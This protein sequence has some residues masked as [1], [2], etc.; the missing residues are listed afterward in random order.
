MFETKNRSLLNTQFIIQLGHLGSG[1]RCGKGSLG[2]YKTP[3]MLSCTFSLGG[4]PGGSGG[5]PGRAW[6][7]DTTLSFRIRLPRGSL[8]LEEFNRDDFP[9]FHEDNGELER[10]F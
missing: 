4:R 8:L 6:S 1:P 5:C 2:Q 9:C 7:V 3:D 10:D